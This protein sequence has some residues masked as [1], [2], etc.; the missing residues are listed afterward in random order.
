[1]VTYD[2]GVI[3]AYA[4][5][6]YRN[7]DAI[8]VLGAILGLAVGWLGGAAAGFYLFRH[9]EAA[10]AMPVIGLVLGCLFG[11][12]SAQGRA[13]A[14]RLQAQIALCQVQIEINTRSFAPS[15]QSASQR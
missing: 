13:M 7:A 10:G 6:L 11:L 12:V 8:L 15:A 14:Y 1:M 5:R 9:S 3:L 2:P 4:G